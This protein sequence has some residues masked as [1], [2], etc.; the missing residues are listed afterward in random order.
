MGPAFVKHSVKHTPL[1][2]TKKNIG[3][4]LALILGGGVAL[5]LPGLDLFVFPSMMPKVDRFPAAPRRNSN[6]FPFGK[7]RA[8]PHTP[9]FG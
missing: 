2:K 3:G 4:L 9:E 5:A 1:S 8:Y 7:S 6:G